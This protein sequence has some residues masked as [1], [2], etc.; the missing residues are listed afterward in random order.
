VHAQKPTIPDF[1]SVVNQ[2]NKMSL[3]VSLNLETIDVSGLSQY[4]YIDNWLIKMKLATAGLL[5]CL[6]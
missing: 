1:F 5:L 3:F 2:L 4:S 6:Q